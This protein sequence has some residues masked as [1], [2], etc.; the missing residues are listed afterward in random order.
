[1]LEQS[2]S[3]ET[4]ARFESHLADCAPRPAYLQTYRRTIAL[5]GRAEHLEMPAEMKMRLRNLLLEA[6]RRGRPSS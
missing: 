4:L 6:P 1:F 3:P 2:L 5:T